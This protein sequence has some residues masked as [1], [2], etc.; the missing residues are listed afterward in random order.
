M[1]LPWLLVSISVKPDKLVERQLLRTQRNLLCTENPATSQRRRTVQSHA[2]ILLRPR[3]TLPSR[4]LHATTHPCNTNVGLVDLLA[5]RR[6]RQLNTNHQTVSAC[7]NRHGISPS[8]PGKAYASTATSSKPQP[9]PCIT[10]VHDTTS[11]PLRFKSINF[12]RR[13]APTSSPDTDTRQD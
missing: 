2:A 12:L 4:R 3:Y 1:P 8:K 11:F 10:G 7:R 13:K 9:P 6:I 5:R